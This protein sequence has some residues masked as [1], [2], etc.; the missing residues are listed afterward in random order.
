MW[1]ELMDE[2][3]TQQGF[4]ERMIE[5]IGMADYDWILE[6][7]GTEG[8]RPVGLMLARSFL[9]GRGIE[10]HADFFPWATARNKIETIATYLRDI[11]KQYKIFVFVPE[12]ETG[13]W[14]RMK[15][16]RVLMSG[17][18]VADCYST[19]EHA[20]LFYTRGP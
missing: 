17:G 8:T 6:A 12:N 3:L 9:A 5:V 15:R 10:P 11:S 4:T 16:Y 7:H 1:R 19:G 14:D 2:G 18:H 20:R 13:F